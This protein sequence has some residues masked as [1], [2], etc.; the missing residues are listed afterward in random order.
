M[1]RFPFISA[2]KLRGSAGTTGNTSIAPY[3]TWGGLDRTRY[4]C[5]AAAC[6]GYR[7]GQ[8]TNPKLVWE[9]TAQVDEGAGFGLF[10]ERKCVQANGDRQGKAPHPYLRSQPP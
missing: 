7:P 3:Q 6:L 1:R 9:R 5:G 4:N 10:Q 8:I 2:L